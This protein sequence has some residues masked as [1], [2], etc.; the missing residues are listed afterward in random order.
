MPLRM[1]LRAGG[2]RVEEAGAGGLQVEAG[3]ARRAELGR[4]EHRGGRQRVVGRAGGHDHEVEV[5]RVQARHRQRVARGM[6]RERGR[7]LVVRGDPS[8]VD[9]GAR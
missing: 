4:D 3:G 9:A 8:L 5:A 7:G 1:K 6:D 2:E